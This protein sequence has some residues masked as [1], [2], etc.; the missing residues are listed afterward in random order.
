MQY[1]CPNLIFLLTLFYSLSNSDWSKNVLQDLVPMLWVSPPQWISLIICIE[2]DGSIPINGNSSTHKLLYAITYELP[3]LSLAS[4]MQPSW[5]LRWARQTCLTIQTIKWFTIGVK[6]QNQVP[7]STTHYY[8]SKN[9]SQCN[10]HNCRPTSNPLRA[11]DSVLCP[12]TISTIK[13][14]YY[15]D[16]TILEICFKHLVLVIVQL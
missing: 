1:E 16:L 12:R 9:F 8:R 14:W 2:A 15:C 11:Q 10:L 4:H 3:A 13:A 7:G 5:H 6:A